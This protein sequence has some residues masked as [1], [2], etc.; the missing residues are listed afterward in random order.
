[1][2]NETGAYFEQ[3]IFGELGLAPEENT[4]KLQWPAIHGLTSWHDAQLFEEDE[5]GNI[6]I[7]VFDI[8]RKVITYKP[9]PNEREYYDRRKPFQIIRLKTPEI[10][11]DKEG[12][13]QTR[14]YVLPKG[15]GTYPYFSFQLCEKYAK[16]EKIHTLV[17]TEGYFKAAKGA[18]C[19][20]DV[21]GFS[22]ITHIK[23]KDTQTM[24][25]DVLK[26]IWKCN[27]ENII[28]L[29]DGDCREISIKDLE[30]GRDLIRRPKGF[31]NQIHKYRELLADQ[32]KNMY[33]ATIKSEELPDRPKGLDDLLI[34]EKEN[35][36]A[37]VDDLLAVS[38]P[39]N[40]F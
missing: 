34:S 24:Y 36:E 21:V 9:N 29:F 19:G 30:A 5:N 13:E 10:Y 28:I 6:R 20:M 18:M 22:S 7:I 27:V 11:T 31:F 8:D 23:D 17:L 35:T 39:C 32:K 33:F 2:T 16:G 26:L 40:F 15:A 1:M 37:V 3:R 38:R 25:A 12:K 14:K 4:V